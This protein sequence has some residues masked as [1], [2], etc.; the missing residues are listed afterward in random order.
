MAQLLARH[1]DINLTMNTYTNLGVAEQSAAVE[2]LPAVP[3]ASPS[4]DE[5]EPRFAVG[6]DAEN[7]QQVVPTM[8]PS[9]AEYGAEQLAPKPPS[10]APNCTKPV[11]PEHNQGQTQ[12]CRKHRPSCNF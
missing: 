7:G 12:P 6:I 8:V 11:D 1:S 5:S 4:P 10:L 3:A 9:G 2:S